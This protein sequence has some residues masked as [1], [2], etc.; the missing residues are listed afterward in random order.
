MKNTHQLDLE[1][2]EALHDDALG[3]ILGGQSV[4]IA[5]NLKMLRVTAGMRRELLAKTLSVDPTSI[6]HWEHGRRVPD[7]DTLIRISDTFN[8]SVDNLIRLK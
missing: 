7:V 8:I 1:K 5:D 6:T 4:D 3:E 2:F